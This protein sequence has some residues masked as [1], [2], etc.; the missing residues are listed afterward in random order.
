[1]TQACPIRNSQNLST[2]I[3]LN[4]GILPKKNTREKEVYF[5]Y[6]TNL[7]LLVAISVWNKEKVCLWQQG[8]QAHSDEKE[9]NEEQKMEKQKEGGE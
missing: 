9:T 4:V 1:M 8:V 3:G 5:P 6:D 7:W 2:E